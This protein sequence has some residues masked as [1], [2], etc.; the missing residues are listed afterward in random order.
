MPLILLIEGASLFQFW[1][2]PINE[3]EHINFWNNYFQKLSRFPSCKS[4]IVL[5]SEEQNELLQL[6]SL[7]INDNIHIYYNFSDRLNGFFYTKYY[8]GTL[9]KFHENKF[10]SDRLLDIYM[11]FEETLI[12]SIDSCMDMRIYDISKISGIY[13]DF[14]HNIICD[15]NGKINKAATDLTSEQLELLYSCDLIEDN[16]DMLVATSLANKIFLQNNGVSKG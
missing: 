15:H 12:K 8:R 6:T 10:P 3:L 16:N 4:P 9:Y 5:N 11:I 2:N 13:Y 1:V 14:L 7:F